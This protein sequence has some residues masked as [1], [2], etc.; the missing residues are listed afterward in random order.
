MTT[1]I[2]QDWSDARRLLLQD[3]ECPPSESLTSMVRRLIEQRERARKAL[4]RARLVSAL[5]AGTCDGCADVADM[6][7][8]DP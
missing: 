8:E 1:P 7:T 3:F 4:R 5:R 2:E 6:T